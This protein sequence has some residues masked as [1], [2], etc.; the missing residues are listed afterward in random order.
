MFL[1]QDKIGDAIYLVFTWGDPRRAGYTGH[2]IDD[3]SLDYDMEAVHRWPNGEA[4]PEVCVGHAPDDP[5]HFK[6]FPYT[7][8]RQA[9]GFEPVPGDPIVFGSW[10]DYLK[11]RTEPPNPE[12]PDVWWYD[13]LD[14]LD[15]AARERRKRRPEAAE[16]VSTARDDVA[17]WVAK[18]HF[19]ADSGIREVWYLPNEA[20]PN[21][22]RLLEVN[23]R[24]IPNDDGVDA[25]EFG[26]DVGGA[27]FQ[28][29]VADVSTDQLE[30][31]KRDPARLPTGW[32]LDGSRAW[33]RRG[34]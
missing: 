3:V 23:D 27:P 28:L 32:S 6:V 25:I 21:A 10:S 16:P 33:R 2:V 9:A 29:S 18:K 12:T 14:K 20:P 26:L 34:A 5:R 11:L 19:V 13:Y 17:E 4:Q 31:I 7:A 8:E 22:I 1:V 15:K 24:F 30:Q